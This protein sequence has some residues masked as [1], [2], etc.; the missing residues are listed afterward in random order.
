MSGAGAERIL[1]YGAGAAGQ[2]VGASFARLE[3]DVTLMARPRLVEALREAPLAIEGPASGR[4]T[5]KLKTIA[6]TRDLSTPPTFVILTVKSFDT[7]GALPD[8]AELVRAG[9]KVLT[10]QNGVGNEETLS[11]ALGEAAVRAGAFTVSVSAPQPGVVTRHTGRGGFGLAP[12]QGAPLDAELALFSSTG[13]PVIVTASHRDLKWSKLLLNVLA[14]A[15]A[16]LLDLAPRDLFANPRA[17]AI[18]RQAFREARAVMRADQIG[19]VDLPAYPV[20]LLV[21]AMAL[22]APVA[23][24]VLAKRVGGGRGDKMPSLWI[25][26]RHGRGRSEVGWLNGAVARAG[27]R[28]GVRTPVNAALTRL[29]EAAVVDASLAPRFARRPDLLAAEV[30]PGLAG[31]D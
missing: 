4:Y 5:V 20:R 15:Q 30:A 22:P 17:F 29:L 31:G 26:L 8:L 12:I 1:V 9:A 28:A 16:A 18:E 19:L 21:L 6:H 10:L 14:N 24:R 27:A 23:R 2:F 11:G 25:D 3:H 7:A 13:L